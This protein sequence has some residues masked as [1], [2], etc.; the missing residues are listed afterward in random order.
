MLLDMVQT[1]MD[2]Q[3]PERRLSAMFRM[4][5][6]HLKRSEYLTRT[7]LGT[8]FASDASNIIEH[9]NRVIYL[10]MMT[11]LLASRVSLHTSEPIREGATPEVSRESPLFKMEIQ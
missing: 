3:L 4:D 9:T 6:D 11:W 1:L 2:L 8:F 5:P 10:R 7:L